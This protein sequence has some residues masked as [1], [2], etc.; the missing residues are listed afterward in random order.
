MG[1]THSLLPLSTRLPCTLLALCLPRPCWRH[2]AAPPSCSGA[3]PGS[4]KPMAHLV[5]RCPQLLVELVLDVLA[6]ALG[7]QLRDEREVGAKVAQRAVE[8][9]GVGVA[10]ALPAQEGKQGLSRRRGKRVW[11]LPQSA[12]LACAALGARPQPQPPHSDAPD[13]PHPDAPVDPR[14][15]AVCALPRGPLCWRPEHVQRRRSSSALT[16]TQPLYHPLL[17]LL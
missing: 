10:P 12:R 3:Q 15:Q 1:R 14:S 17:T 5:W 2:P 6:V 8:E 7:E 11:Q 9:L 4:P 16:L 13:D